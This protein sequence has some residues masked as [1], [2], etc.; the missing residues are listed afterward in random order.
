M[1]KL[2]RINAEINELY[3]RDT[4]PENPQLLFPLIL[5]R[6]IAFPHL[7]N[8]LVFLDGPLGYYLIPGA[9]LAKKR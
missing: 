6:L 4:Q 1:D 3:D 9:R 8:Q 5:N 7:K 2:E